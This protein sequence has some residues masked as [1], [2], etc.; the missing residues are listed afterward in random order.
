M[1]SL[2]RAAAREQREVFDRGE[3]QV[4]LVW[5]CRGAGVGMQAMGWTRAPAPP[6]Q[7]GGRENALSWVGALNLGRGQRD[8]R[9]GGLA[10]PSPHLLTH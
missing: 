7:P 8:R 5:G 3:L 10:S 9:D 1:A 4:G 6:W 2:R